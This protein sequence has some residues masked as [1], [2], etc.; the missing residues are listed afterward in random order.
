[1]S[2]VYFDNVKLFSAKNFIH[3]VDKIYA[4]RDRNDKDN[5]EKFMRHVKSTYDYFAKV[6]RYRIEILVFTLHYFVYLRYEK[7]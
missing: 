6:G 4:H 1:M 5:K 2:V 7:V 3:N